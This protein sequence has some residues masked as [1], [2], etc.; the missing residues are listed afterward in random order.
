MKNFDWKKLIP[1]IAAILIFLIVSYVY[2]KP[3]FEGMV[4]QQSDILHWKGMAHDGELYAAKHGQPPLW[5]KTLFGGMPTFQIGYAANNHVP[6][7]F[8]NT[9]FT[10]GLPIPASM[11]FVACLMFY[12]LAI[13]LRVNPWIGIAGAIGYAYST[14]DPV[15]ISVGHNTKMW[16]IAFMPA[17]LASLLLIY[18]KRYWIGAA[19]TALFTSIMIDMNHLQITYYFMIIAVI[20]T[21]GYSIKWLREKQAG[22]F[23]RAAIFAIIS[24]GIGVA[25]NA[26][27][28]M[29][30]YDYQKESIR[31]RAPLAMTDSAKSKI[32]NE[33]IDKDYAFNYSMAI[34]EPLVLMVPGMF[35]GSSD[36][37]EMPED[38]S[39]TLEAV[40]G[41]TQQGQQFFQQYG[42]IRGTEN[43]DAYVPM[44]WGGIGN[45]PNPGTSGPPYVGA[46]ICFLAILSLFL[47]DG[48]YK[49]WAWTAIAAAVVMSWG[50]NFLA[51]NS[52]LFDHL[53]FYNKFRAPS[54]IMVIP[55]LLLPM[56]AVL[57]VDKIINAEN[58][59][60][61]FTQFKKGLIATAAVLVLLL[62]LYFTFDF[63][64]QADRNVI[65]QIKESGQPQLDE[66]VNTY[67]N[68]LVEDRKSMMLGDIMRSFGFIAVVA[69]LLFFSIRKNISKYIVIGAIAVLVAI[70]IFPVDS[71]YLASVDYKEP[72]QNEGIFNPN[73]ADQM[74]LQDKSDF[75]VFN[76]SDP[77]GPFNDAITCYHHRSVGGYHPAK[78][79]IY[80]DLIENQI[81]KNNQ[82]VLDMLN[83][84][85]IIQTGQNG[86]PQAFI[87]GSQ[88]GSAWFVKHIQYEDGDVKVMK[89]LDHFNPKDTAI[90]DR[91]F[92]KTINSQP[93][94]DS[95]AKIEL[96]LNDND[97]VKYKSTSSTNQFAVFSEIYYN[98]GWK[99]YVDGKE[100]PIIRV[101]YVLRGLSLPAGNHEIEFRFKPES[102]TSSYNITQYS[103]LLLV[104]MLVAGIFLEWRS[105]KK[106][107]AAA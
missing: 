7:F 60:I 90:V 83:T 78:L 98:R 67:Y 84:K 10:L 66:L 47:V 93:V 4:L 27:I 107:T 94:Y 69:G 89:A 58:K 29:P 49:W 76:L 19:L 43:G 54:M 13:V 53:P 80:Q 8:A 39:K 62:V 9:F 100:T 41:M 48:K 2:C 96:V 6:W 81:A 24:A 64:S 56:L 104:L 92:E 75:R 12:F 63:R 72:S 57:S 22:H 44:Y 31:G 91:S 37:M 73:P 28:M 5:N 106:R 68:A 25:V 21:I 102:Y 40:R 36:N 59:E 55:Q 86:Q 87:R 32:T 65:K 52:F 101:N 20:L 33:G 85:Y 42:F 30:T 16:T 35:G 95:A 61:V 99:A 82:A 74:I 70:D 23:I 1:H 14:Y 50:H 79:R 97:N 26:V 71:K 105:Y 51:L 77:N 46:I 3:A 38:K 15:I 103:Q 34:S 45:G 17:V 11:F 18:N 88:L